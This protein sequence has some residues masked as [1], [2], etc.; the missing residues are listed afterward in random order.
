MAKFKKSEITI[1]E[2]YSTDG[3]EVYDLI[4]RCRPLDINS[5]YCNLLQTFHFRETSAIS[6]CPDNT[7]YGFV[8]GYMIPDLMN[9][10]F[11]WQ[12]AVDEQARGLG[13]GK[14]MILDIINRNHVE[15]IH[16]TI[17]KDNKAS[18]AVFKSLTKQLKSKLHYSKFFDKDIH[19]DG[20][21]KTEYLVQVGPFNPTQS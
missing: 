7:V 21:A 15:Y 14:R 17:T 2:P 11:I 13:L 5:R 10:L 12:V 6:V 16:T 19:F 8:S 18:W 3:P 9:T 4:K 20:E 1:R